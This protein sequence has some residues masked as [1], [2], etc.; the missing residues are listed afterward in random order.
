MYTDILKKIKKVEYWEIEYYELDNIIN[1]EYP[2]IDYE[3]A[4]DQ[5]NDSSI[6]VYI[7]GELTSN[8]ETYLHRLINNFE[9]Q[10]YKATRILMNDLCRKG[11]LPKGNYLIN[12]NW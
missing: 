4:L 5:H 7:D 12:V 3:C 10:D 8:D 2:D 1:T 11:Y 9:H 6:S